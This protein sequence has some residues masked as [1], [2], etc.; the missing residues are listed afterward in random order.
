LIIWISGP[1]GAGKSTLARCLGES[2]FSIVGEDVSGHIFS[3]F[4]SQ[5]AAHCEALERHLM[6]ARLNEWRRVA[7]A[8]V[9]AFDRSIDEDINVFCELHR[10]TGLLTRMQFEKLNGLARE[11]QQQIPGPDL[12]LFVTASS[13]V[14]RRRLRDANAPTPILANLDRQESL[15]SQWLQ[16]RT[17]EVMEINTTRLSDRAMAKFFRGIRVC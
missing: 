4:V 9:I 1:T 16:T 8:P 14:L 13:D 12:I 3:S 10:Q 17:E 6:V 15:Y 7:E 11:L 5:P 2:G